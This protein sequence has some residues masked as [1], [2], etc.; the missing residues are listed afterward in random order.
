MTVLQ[1]ILLGVCQGISEFLPISSSGH[2]VLLQSL[3][4]ITEGSVL[5]TV[6]LHFG[7]LASI[8]I[9][10]HKDVLKLIAEFFKMIGEL[11]T[12]KGLNLDNPY[13]KL[14]ILLI[15]GS[16]PTA[17]MGVLFKDFF[18]SLYSS[19]FSVGIALI[20]TGC[21]LM[22]SEKMATGKKDIKQFRYIDAVIIGTLQGFAIT[23]GISRSG[24]TIVGGLL[25][26][27]NKELATK[28]SFFLALPSIFGA[29]ILKVGDAV[30]KGIAIDIPIIVGTIVS[31][32]VGLFAIKFLIT[33]LKKGK[34]Y[35]FSYYLWIIGG[36]II[37][38]NL[39][40]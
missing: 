28:F 1:A 3:F 13:R 17:I 2:L 18:E 25:L 34:L 19:V 36:L 16:V 38:Y 15:V 12:G 37:I 9:F 11:L 30:A 7:S 26:G 33:L 29:T 31:T 32:V 40:R 6:M 35:Y 24:S 27:L 39:A 10:Y 4:N 23:P 22:I 8:L 20:I 5:F 21:I 14:D